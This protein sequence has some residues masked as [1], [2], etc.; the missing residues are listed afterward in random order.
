M[1][2]TTKARRE[3]ISGTLLGAKR[4]PPIS[5]AGL[6]VLRP[7]GLRYPANR[8]VRKGSRILRNKT[9]SERGSS[10]ATC[11]TRWYGS[12]GEPLA[13]PPGD[14]ATSVASQQLGDSRGAWV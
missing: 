7:S 12:A 8:P 9:P 10:G 1:P 5:A 11:L 14:V 6:F 3:Q 2:E 4:L 13:R